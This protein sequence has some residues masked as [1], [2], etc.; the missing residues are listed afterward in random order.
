MLIFTTGYIQ[1]VSG[2]FTK[3][4]VEVEKDSMTLNKIVRLDLTGVQKI[5]A[6]LF[7]MSSFIAVMLYGVGSERGA[8][9]TYTRP[10][11]YMFWCCMV[12]FW[13][14]D[15]LYSLSSK[16]KIIGRDVFGIEMQKRRRGSGFMKNV[17]GYNRKGG[18]GGGGGGRDGEKTEE[19]VDNSGS[20]AGGI[21]FSPGFM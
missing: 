18:G 1:I 4:A 15:I 9:V 7:G 17:N 8:P 21:D 6:Y 16:I 19:E 14:I 20:M 3:H 2:I 12:L 5:S 10:V 13:L 11:Y